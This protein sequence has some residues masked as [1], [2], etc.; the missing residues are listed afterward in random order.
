MEEKEW[1]EDDGDGDD[2]VEI[3]AVQL[4]GMPNE[5]FLGKGTDNRN[6]KEY[7]EEDNSK[8]YANDGCKN[9]GGGAKTGNK[10]RGGI[11]RYASKG[12]NEEDADSW[13]NLDVGGKDGEDWE[14]TKGTTMTTNI[15]ISRKRRRKRGGG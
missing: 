10:M 15:E 14:T 1:E 4:F 11:D 8:G 13:H 3:N 6:K 9:S 7:E 5:A 2:V 12:D